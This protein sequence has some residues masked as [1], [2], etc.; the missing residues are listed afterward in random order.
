MDK[1]Q[2]LLVE[3]LRNRI[4]V[5]DDFANN[6]PYWIKNNCH[7]QARGIEDALE[8]IDRVLSIYNN[9]W[10]SVHN[11]LPEEKENPLTLDYFV[12]PV[13][14]QLEDKSDIR[15]YSFGDGHWWNGPSC[16]DAYVTHWMD[17]KPYEKRE[18]YS[19]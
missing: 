15:Y 12:Y 13:M 2:T 19:F 4:S 5:I 17:I 1:L 10:I 8:I 14:V 3:E 9:G 7:H 6:K 16:M 18:E 11:Q